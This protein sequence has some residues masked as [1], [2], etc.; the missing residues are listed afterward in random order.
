M[1]DGATDRGLALLLAHCASLDPAAPTARERLDEKLGP[2]LA[3]KLVFALAAREH[4]G[5]RAPQPLRPR[6][7]FAA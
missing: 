4:E 7:I 5:D 3:R 6:A 2:E 1:R